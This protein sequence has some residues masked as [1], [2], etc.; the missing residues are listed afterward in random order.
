MFRGRIDKTGYYLYV[1]YSYLPI[2]F[3]FVLAD[4][5]I[6]KDKSSLLY[7]FHMPLQYI[8]IG[9]V[10]FCIIA[11]YGISVRRWHDNNEPYDWRCFF[12]PYPLFSGDIGPNNYGNPQHPRDYFGVMF[13]TGQNKNRSK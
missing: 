9:Y 10:V 12:I 4:P 5:F 2:L 8:A 7:Q 11:G 6:N 3:F 1:L 13:G